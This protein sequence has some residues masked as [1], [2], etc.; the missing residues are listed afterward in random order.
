MAIDPSPTAAATRFTL[1]DRTSQLQKLRVGSF[2][3]FVED[4]QRP[5]RGLRRSIEI[6][7][8]EDEALL[9]RARQ[10]LSQL[11]LGEAPAIMTRGGFHW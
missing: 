1:P 10:P 7:P 8:C 3:A 4:G 9:S 11:V 2:P 5:N 6:P